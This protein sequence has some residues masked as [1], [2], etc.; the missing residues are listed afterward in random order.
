MVARTRPPALLIASLALALLPTHAAAAHQYH[1]EVWTEADVVGTVTLSV[2]GVPFLEVPD[3]Q[4]F[5]H[6]HFETGS[7]CVSGPGQYYNLHNANLQQEITGEADGF[8]GAVW[9]YAGLTFYSADWDVQVENPGIQPDFSD[10][11]VSVSLQGGYAEPDVNDLLGFI[12]KTVYGLAG[13]LD[14]P[15]VPGLTPPT[16]TGGFT[17]DLALL[18]QLDQ[19][20]NG[21]YGNGFADIVANIAEGDPVSASYHAQ[22][23]NGHGVVYLEEPTA[24]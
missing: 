10:R 2:G 17:Y 1:Y 18:R 3:V 14:T 9:T 7:N 8:V 19:T 16:A 5:I 22:G 11:H 12:I 23:E 4:A 21:Q 20:Q 24:C 13:P 6:Y 15:S